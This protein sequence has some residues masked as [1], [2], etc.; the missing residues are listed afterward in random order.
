MLIVLPS[1]VGDVVMATPFIR[2]VRRR[3][4]SARLAGLVRPNLRALIDDAEWLDDLLVWETVE[5]G[6]RHR[7]SL[8]RTAARLR[9]ERFD[10]AVLLPN[11]FSAALATVMARIPR[12]IGYQRDG[13]GWLLTDRVRVPRV[14]GKIVPSPLVEYYGRL[15]EAIGCDAPGDQLELFTDPAAEQA[16]DERLAA[17]GVAGTRP[18]V[19]ISPGASF[20]SSKLWLPDRFAAL[21]DRLADEFGAA[22]LITCAPGEESMAQQVAAAMQRPVHVLADPVGTLAEFKALVR[23]ADLLVNNDTGPRHIAKAFGV[24]VVTIFGSTFPEW[25]DTS[26]QLER[27]VRI[28][29]DC[30]P[31]QQKVCPFGH[32]KC[33]TGVTVDMVLAACR[34]LLESRLAAPLI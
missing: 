33:I 25:T 23:R 16:I 2:A 8:R 34:A 18:L 9:K 5:R 12:R 3:F 22:I 14:G 7:R 29:V 24:P 13:R 1:W 26:Y 27:K 17:M 10:A 31:C 4:S 28:D 15:A 20:G 21:G 19:L 11:S 32:H 6:G 30:G